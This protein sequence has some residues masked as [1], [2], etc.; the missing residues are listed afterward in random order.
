MKKQNGADNW[1]CTPAP[2]ESINLEMI[3]SS[4]KENCLWNDVVSFLHP[5]SQLALEFLN[6]SIENDDLKEGGIYA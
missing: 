6:N 2:Q 3:Y 4:V 5:F 1:L